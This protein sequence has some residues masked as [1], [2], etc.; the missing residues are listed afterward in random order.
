MADIIKTK[1]FELAVLA[2][3]DQNAKGLALLLP[4]RLDTKD[5][6]CFPSHADYL[7]ELDFYAVAF[8]PPGTWESPGGIDLYT[9]TNYIQAVNELIEY[10]G[11]RMTLLMGHSRGAAVSIFASANSAVV[12]IIPVM[13]SFGEPTAPGEEAVRK[14]YKLSHRD[15]PPGTSKTIEQKEFKLPITYWEDGEQYNAGEILKTCRKPK[16]LIYGDN[17][18]FTPVDVA[19]KLFEE[20]PDPKMV[21]ELHSTHNYR[22]SR[23]VIEEINNELGKFLHK[24]GQPSFFD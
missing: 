22:Y 14:G 11:N 17:D 20:I 9:T 21:K 5:Y 18:E 6:A 13:A 10:F 16:L 3:G 24:W 1:S 23:V 12:G 2:R 15:L 8:D 7:A 4:G 19:K